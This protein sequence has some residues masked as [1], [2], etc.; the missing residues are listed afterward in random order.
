MDLRKIKKLIEL[1]EESDI[2]EL[3]V[4]SGEEAVRI[5]RGGGAAGPV[6]GA[7]AQSAAVPG[8]AVP[9]AA[10][11]STAPPRSRAVAAPMSGTFYVAPEPGADPFVTVGARIR[12][13]DVLCIIE[14][15]KMMHRIEAEVAGTLSAP[16]V[17][18]GD[19]VEAGAHLFFV[20]ED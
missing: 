12:P 11:D 10:R 8:A 20:A 19:P 15:M 7:A 13:G 18:N 2:A 16:L 1:V 6:P 4:R 14:S 17:Q 9:G 5:R 3:E